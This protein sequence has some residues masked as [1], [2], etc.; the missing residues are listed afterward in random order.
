MVNPAR[1]HH[2]LTEQRLLVVAGI[3]WLDAEHLIVQ[4]RSH[5]ATHGGGRLE[6]P[7]GKVERG[8]P[9]ALALA[10]EL[11]EEWG[12]GAGVLEIGPIAEVLHHVY[13][14]PGREVVLLVYHV[15]ARRLATRTPPRPESVLARLTPEDGASAHV[16]RRVA[17]PLGEF[18]DAD[19]PCVAQLRSARLRCPWT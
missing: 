6:L 8:E 10:R 13:P 17:L 18:L 9:P 2:A 19:R 11:V 12:E 3:V 1:T 5:T 4:R 14:P 16:V 7:G 15:D